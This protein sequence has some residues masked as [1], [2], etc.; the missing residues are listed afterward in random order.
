MKDEAILQYK[1]TKGVVKN[2]FLSPSEQIKHLF[3]LLG[4]ETMFVVL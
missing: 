1:N 3:F 4:H 2:K